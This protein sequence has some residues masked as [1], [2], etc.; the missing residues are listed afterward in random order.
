MSRLKLLVDSIVADLIDARFDADVR[1]AELA[2]H[3]RENESMRALSIPAL[4]IKNVS[5]DL[6]FAFDDTPIEAAEGPSAEQTKAVTEAA[7]SVRDELMKLPQVTETVTVDRQRST[8]SRALLTA[9]K[10]AMLQNVD[11]KP[12]D[13]SGA[14]TAEVA[15]TLTK[16]GV[17]KLPAAEWDVLRNQIAK[18]EAAFGAAPK[19]A[20]KSLPGVVVGTEALSKV[21]PGAVSKLT[22]EV[23]LSKRRWTEVGDREA[24]KKSVLSD[25]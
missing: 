17:A 2:E 18:L 22:F 13:R 6:R 9:L 23:D 4:N 24:G 15:N 12:A 21:D 14:V 7:P 3:Y 1:A 10:N 5:I 19:A 16:N 20:P 8:L 25:T 11:A